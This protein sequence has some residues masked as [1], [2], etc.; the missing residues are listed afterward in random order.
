MC[1]STEILMLPYSFCGVGSSFSN[2]VRGIVFSVFR[3]LFFLKLRSEAAVRTKESK[4][5]RI[6]SLVGNVKIMNNNNTTGKF[7]N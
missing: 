6:V 5:S 3:S 1:G 4:F 7:A 2:R